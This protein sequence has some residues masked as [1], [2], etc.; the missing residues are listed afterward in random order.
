MVVNS[1]LKMIHPKH[2]LVSMPKIPRENNFG[3]GILVHSSVGK[4]KSPLYPHTKKT[5]PVIFHM[6][7]SESSRVDSQPK[8]QVKLTHLLVRCRFVASHS[9]GVANLV[10]LWWY[11]NRGGTV[12]HGSEIRLTSWYGK[13]PIIYKVSCSS[14]VVQDFFHQQDHQVKWDGKF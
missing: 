7:T 8:R 12:V 4:W 14:W 1:N 9:L 13:Y 6:S 2:H 10:I 5:T 3:H 11:P